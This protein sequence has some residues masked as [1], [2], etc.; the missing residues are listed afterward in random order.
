[1]VEEKL[2]MQLSGQRDVLEETSCIDIRV[3]LSPAIV[4]LVD[5]ALFGCEVGSSHFL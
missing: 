1:M 2:E 5:E 4:E 3:E